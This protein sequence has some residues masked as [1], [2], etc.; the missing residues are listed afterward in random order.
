[1]AVNKKQAQIALV[2]AKLKKKR[3][4]H[5]QQTQRNIQEEEVIDLDEKMSVGSSVEWTKIYDA[6]ATSQVP[7]IDTTVPPPPPPPPPQQQQQQPRMLG[8]TYSETIAVARAS[9]Q[10]MCAESIALIEGSRTVT[11]K[12]GESLFESTPRKR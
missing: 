5:S 8:L 7:P 2:R 6:V 4:L 1:M 9:Q 12:Q 3:K 11:P 10:K